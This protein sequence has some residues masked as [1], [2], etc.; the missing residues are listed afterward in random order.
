MLRNI[1]SSRKSKLTLEGTLELA[2]NHLDSA[3]KTSDPTKSLRHCRNA[4]SAIKDAEKIFAAKKVEDP[5][6]HNSIANLYHEHGKLLDG[7]GYYSKAKRSHIKAKEWGYV[8]TVSQKTES[9]LPG[10][11]SNSSHGS[12]SPVSL[13]DLSGIEAEKSKNTS[14]PDTAQSSLQSQSQNEILVVQ[15]SIE[16]VKPPQAI[17]RQDVSPPVA[18]YT[19]PEDDERITSTP[20][21]AYCLSL[22]DPSLISKE[23]LDN[24][25]F[26]WS[27]AKINN[28]DEQARLKT[29]GT[30]VVK[31]FVRDELKKP[32]VVAE[33][34][35]LAAVLE[36][37]DFRKVLQAFVDGI[38]Q[39]VLLEVHLL[40]G[41][42]QLMR[43]AVQGCFDADDL[44][45]ILRLLNN[46]LKDTHK[47]SAEHT[48]RLAMTISRVLDSMV[49]SQVKGLSREQLHE[50]LSDYLKG[51]QGSSDPY[52][53]Y[54]AVYAFQALQYVPDDETILQSMLRRTG[55]VVQ[56]ISGV[57]SAVKALDLNG[58][59][60]GLQHIQ[61]GL[62]AVG[63]AIE[64]AHDA[65][66]NAKALVESGQ[67]FLESLKEG[68]S[69]TRKSAWYPALRGLDRL[70]QEGQFAEVERLIREAPCRLDPAF[71]WG[72]C[73]R[74]GE[75]AVNTAWDAN[76]RKGALTFLADQLAGST[77]SIV[78]SESKILMEELRTDGD[79]EKQMLYE[80]SRKE[81]SVPYPMT[82]T[83]P[84]QKSPLLGCVQNKPD[85][86]T[87]LRQL[88]RERLKERGGDVYISP[89]AKLNPRATDDFDLTSK[90]Q[91]FIDSDRK[92][93]LIL[94]DSGAGKST[95]NRALEISLWDKYEK[96]TGRIPLFI[97]LPVIDKPEQDLIAKQLHKF[98]FTEKQI[99]ELKAYR[100]FIV[101]CDGYDESQ[102]TRNLYMSNQL[103][104][105]GGWRAQMVISC[106]SEY[107]GVDYKDRFQPTDRNKI[108]GSELFQEATIVPFNK[109][110]IQDYI[111]QY[112][113]LMKP[114]WDSKD[115][116]RAINQIPNLQGLVENPFLLKLA[117]DVLPRLFNTKSDFKTARVT[118]IGLYDEFIAQWIERSKIRLGDMELSA[119]DKEAFK[120]LSQSGFKQHGITYLKELTTAIYDHHGGNPVI[121]YSEYQDQKTWKEAFFNKKDGKHL[122]REAIPLIRNGDQC[123]FI[124]KS[125]VEYGLALAVFDPNSFTE[126]TEPAPIVSRRGST[127][128]ALS[129]E[130]SESTDKISPLAIEQPLL[131]SP[132]GRKHFVSETAVLQFLVDRAQQQ[133]VFK[134]QLLAVIERSKTDKS[135]RVA[136]ANAITVLVKAG[137][138]FNGA[139][140][141]GIKV[142][143]ADLSYGAFDSVHL[144]GAD[145]RKANL[146]S[147]WLRDANLDG[148][149]MAGVH[150]GELPF[151]Q[152]DSA[153]NCCAY[154]PNG[155]IFAAGLSNG[156]ICL[157]TTSN[158]ERIQIMR[159]QTNGVRCLV[160]S[161][162]GGQ[163]ATGNEDKTVRLWDIETGNCVHTL[164]GHSNRIDTVLYSPKGDQVASAGEDD[165]T[166]WLWNV[167][168]GACVHALKDHFM[169]IRSI[170]YSPSG[171]QIASAGWDEAVRLWDVD[172]GN[173]IRIMRG[174]NGFILKIEYSPRGDL[175]ASA[176]D[177]STVRLWDVNTG[178]CIHN[179]QGHTYG[180]TSVAYSPK[181]GQI[182][183][184]GGDNTLRLWDVDTG[185]C[186]HTLQGHHDTIKSVMYSP[187]GDQIVSRSDDKTLR[188]WDADSG[189]CIHIL[190][191]HTGIVSSVVYS[192]RGDQIASGSYDKTVR[193]WD[194]NS[195]D[196]VHT[197]QGHT[198]RIRSV[199]CSPKGDRIA[200]AGDD[201]TVRLWDVNTGG[202]VHILQEH[203]GSVNLIVYSPTGD[204]IASASS[205][206][207]VRLWNS[208]TGICV[209]ILQGHDRVVTNIAYSP[210]GDRIASGSDDNTL[211]LWDAETGSCLHILQGHM[212]HITSVVY[213]SKDQISSSDSYVMRLW[214][215]DT[216][217]CVRA[218]QA[219][220]KPTLYVVEDPADVDHII[221]GDINNRVRLW[222][223]DT[224]HGFYTLGSYI[225]SVEY[226]PRGDQI[227]YASV[228]DN[229]L[230]LDVETGN[231]VHSLQGHTDSVWH[232]VYSLKGDMI[233]SG[234]NDGTVRVWSTETGQCLVTISGFSQNIKSIAWRNSVNGHYLVTGGQD[235]SVR[236]WQ[237]IN[238]QDGYNALM[239]WSSLYEKL[240][241]S[242]A[243]F[244]NVQGLGDVNL[245]ILSQR[246]A[247]ITTSLSE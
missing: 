25:E 118:R 179:F 21:L 214:D 3:H 75:L 123:R 138:Q 112:V 7:L 115:Y 63:S 219:G 171:D 102:Q 108:G 161:A 44:V 160:F 193:L 196:C 205:D 247:L 240:T 167:N 194:V 222:N 228:K 165:E 220:S 127:S 175:I 176:S 154:S 35:C 129:F 181:G 84:P 24:I 169:G 242:G 134:D 221:P 43:N 111:N 103:N 106:R 197:Q 96:T 236:Y 128:S 211:R 166:L 230:L 18:K 59:I 26:V 29:M 244:N 178:N 159:G 66:S 41:L 198:H 208:D 105:P 238:E 186:I 227:A 131:D 210:K 92:V 90:V 225:K 100:E 126:N 38:E 86:E 101:I 17:F 16:A 20:Q 177:D 142:P 133:I 182:V 65:F 22:L 74:L 94:G 99:R 78:S 235:K 143:G 36:R 157:Y 81:R 83:L 39:S 201:C 53:V 87:P 183:S 145:L 155:E 34:V 229:V 207:T 37:D 215:V 188:V 57:V 213:L 40:D 132:L 199:V 72:V 88:K 46:R 68:L 125:L 189:N 42:A 2:S 71:Q 6:L 31:A 15:K 187:R 120:I 168:T 116:L 212:S 223:A 77:D 56:G 10:N 117:L 146:R 204:Q 192:P 153:V 19:L 209:H 54:Q 152:E 130:I 27:Q 70:L 11:E 158:W 231:V 49:D 58:F 234:S 218:F 1:F 45:K 140:L 148:A 184:G 144:E 80:T 113:A 141:R 62:A 180:A 50:P 67:G 55:K 206:Q 226:S 64:I 156:D 79:A 107:T 4:K 109:D 73:Q 122:L 190:Q 203:T 191:G 23:G 237:I 51:L 246:G 97:H 61:G 95:F 136:A 174:H 124:H 69:F 91:G 119:F 224:G 30:D 121:N 135:A 60:E 151:L 33:V 162:T 202:C 172:T 85:V 47:Q 239:C 147:I 89:R 233:A 5:A 163:V 82:V 14:G 12:L 149:Q 241:V 195:G 93:F 9:S 243:S 28:V 104:Q 200:S 232:I 32:D 139:D 217:D 164:Q 52:M 173:C 76:T 114:S 216:G 245:K 13:S 110:Q 170:A 8:Y 137:V 48:Y 150:F 98:D 185:E